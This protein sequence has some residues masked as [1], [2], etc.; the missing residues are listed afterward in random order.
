MKTSMISL[1]LGAAACAAACSLAS[2]HILA[3]SPGKLPA[4]RA[5]GKAPQRVLHFDDASDG[6]NTAAGLGGPAA[7][8]RPTK[9]TEAGFGGVTSEKAGLVCARDDTCREVQ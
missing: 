3:G 8:T 7:G 1:L 2:W 5:A 4:Q 9:S 6:V